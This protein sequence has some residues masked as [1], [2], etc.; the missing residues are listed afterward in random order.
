M[1]AEESEGEAE[2]RRISRRQKDEGGRI[3]QKKGRNII[4]PFHPF[5]LGIVVFAAEVVKRMRAQPG[6]S[7]RRPDI[8]AGRR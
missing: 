3:R 1:K 4:P 8:D 2:G 6:D 7:S 5:A